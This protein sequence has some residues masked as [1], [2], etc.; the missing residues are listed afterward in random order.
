MQ[1]EVF[2][3]LETIALNSKHTGSNHRPKR[4]NWFILDASSRKYIKHHKDDKDHVSK[5]KSGTLSD[6]GEEAPAD[7]EESRKVQRTTEMIDVHE[8][9]KS[10]KANKWKADEKKLF[11]EAVE[12]FG[13][14][15]F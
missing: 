4:S 3:N 11:F 15:F 8:E 14:Y 7:E 12:L 13:K 9:K 5:R 10:A 2:N 1:L 6:E